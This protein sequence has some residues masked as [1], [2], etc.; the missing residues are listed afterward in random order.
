LGVYDQEVD[1]Y[2]GGLNYYFRGQNLK[3]TLEYSTVEFDTETRDCQDFDTLTAQLQ[4][5][6]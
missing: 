1:W 4:V 6:F 5:I 3:L 2:G